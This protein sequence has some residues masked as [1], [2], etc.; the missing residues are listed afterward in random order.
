MDRDGVQ[1]TII[2]GLDHLI[3]DPVQRRPLSFRELV[4]KGI[5]SITCG[6]VYD[7]EKVDDTPVGF[8]R[9][10]TMKRVAGSSIKN[11]HPVFVCEVLLITL[12]MRCCFWRPGPV[13]TREL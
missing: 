5:I 4:F 8:Y 7:R 11:V 10:T 13:A 1:V 2:F 9:M 12:R 3:K 6:V